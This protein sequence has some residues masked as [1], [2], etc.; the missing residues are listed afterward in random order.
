[1]KI[2]KQ[3]SRLGTRLPIRSVSLHIRDYQV[4]LKVKSDVPQAGNRS[5]SR[6][7]VR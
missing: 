7:V 5:L 3:Q 2:F 6:P 1:M 4:T